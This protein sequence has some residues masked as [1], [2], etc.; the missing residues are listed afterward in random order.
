MDGMWE[1]GFIE[2][3][4]HWVIEWEGALSGYY[5]ANEEGVLLQFFLLPK[6]RR[7]SQQ[8]FKKIIGQSSVKSAIVQTIDPEFLSLCLDNHVAVAV[9]TYL[10]ELHTEVSP[11]HPTEEGTVFEPLSRGDLSRVIDFQVSC[12]GGQEH[13]RHW[14]MGYSTNLIGS[15][16]ESCVKAIPLRMAEG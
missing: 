10:Y 6:Y 13:L 11:Q 9:H 5:A 8:I 7:F 3:S 16:P 12:L 2:S 1:V 14:L 15:S 4:P